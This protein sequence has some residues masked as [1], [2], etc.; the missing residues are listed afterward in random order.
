MGD[1]GFHC[2]FLPKFVTKSAVL[3]NRRKNNFMVNK[4]KGNMPFEMEA[5]AAL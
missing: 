3:W 1:Q 5:S 4:P 2:I